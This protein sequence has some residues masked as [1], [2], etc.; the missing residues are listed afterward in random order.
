MAS[1][2]FGVRERGFT[3]LEI[4]VA[5]AIFAT[6]AAAVLSASQ[7]VVKQTRGVEERLLAAWLADNQLSE[8]RLQP[9]LIIGQ[10]QRLM[11]MDR[12]EWLLRQ[13]ISN[14]SDP[15][16]L[17]VDVDV[18]LA[19]REQTMYSANGWIADRHE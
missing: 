18:S 12:R 14:T 8:L 16:L 10:Q 4:M 5:L 2:L 13:R 3:L 9:R 17:K 7:Y 19:G 11:S 6:L 15:R 1:R